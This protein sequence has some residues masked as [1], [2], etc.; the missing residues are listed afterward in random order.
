VLCEAELTSIILDTG[1]S[2]INGILT[3]DSYTGMAQGGFDFQGA[4][5]EITWHNT[6]RTLTAFCPPTG[7]KDLHTAGAGI[8]SLNLE[9]CIGA[10][11]DGSL[12]WLSEYV[13]VQSSLGCVCEASS[14]EDTVD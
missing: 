9:D 3:C 8:S 2:N 14:K 1:I 7:A 11:Y 10:A 12:M 5:T 13:I 4:C 6:N